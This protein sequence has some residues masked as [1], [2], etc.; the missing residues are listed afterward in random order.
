[1]DLHELTIE[2]ALETMRRGEASSVELTQAFLD[3][4]ERYDGQVGAF[5]LVARERALEDARRADERRRDGEETPLLGVPIAL[6][7]L[8]CTRGIETTCASRIL[9]GFVPPYDAAVTERLA[10]AGAVMIGKTNMDEFAMGSSTEN[11]AYQVTRNPWDLSRV[12]GGS[13]GGSAAAVA[14]G[15]A[16]GSFGTDTGG[17]IRQ[18][19]SLCGVVGMK[20]TYGRISRYGMIAFASSLDQAGPFARTVSDAAR[21]L[22]AVAGPDPYDS[23]SLPDPVPDYLSDL[24]RDLHGIRVGVPDEYFVAGLEPGVEQSV[25]RA[26]DMLAEL[27][28]D[29]NRVTMPHTQYY[30]GVKYGL[31]ASDANVMEMYTRTRGQGFGAEVKRRIMLGTY[32]LSAGYYDA[33][34]VKAQK[35]RTL[36]KSDF[37]RAFASFDVIVAPTSPTVAFPLGARTNDPLAMYLSDVYT[38]PASLAGLPA[39][40]LPCGLADGLPVGLQIVGPPLAEAR[41]LQVAA[42]YE[43]A[44][45]WNARLAPIV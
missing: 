27:G 34:Y 39:I 12:P 9:E 3:R 10:S 28:A 35:V 1:L 25:R 42:A 21:L 36:I 19:A 7:D 24:D 15:F 18:P 11:S 22:R 8:F 20:P 38:L 16:A 2:Q 41:V 17:S 4:V 30:D 13:S 6:K 45:G 23:T 26:V 31:R 44:G 32:A 43:R 37:D 14:A 5:L 29:V 40:S 33:F